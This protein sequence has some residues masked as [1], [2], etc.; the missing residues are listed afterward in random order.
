MHRLAIGGEI[1]TSTTQ[2]ENI[3]HGIVANILYLILILLTSLI[4]LFHQV[5]TFCYMLGHI[6]FLHQ[7]HQLFR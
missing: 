3:W 5:F 7:L 1:P 6:I 2:H 4:C